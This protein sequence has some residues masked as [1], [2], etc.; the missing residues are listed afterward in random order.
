MAKLKSKASSSAQSNQA[1][2]PVVPDWKC[3]G[4]LDYSTKKVYTAAQRD[5]AVSEARESASNA[6]TQLER[7]AARLNNLKR[8]ISELEA[9]LHT[10]K[11]R[12]KDLQE[13]FDDSLLALTRHLDSLR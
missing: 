6:Q 13:S 7:N 2:T 4:S 5:K 1:G 8:E 3:D 9:Q 12:Y 11:M 10:S